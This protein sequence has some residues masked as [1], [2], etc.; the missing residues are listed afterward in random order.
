M[1]S[2]NVNVFDDRGSNSSQSNSR[3]LLSPPQGAN[4]YLLIPTSNYA[5]SSVCSS[6]RHSKTDISGSEVN[7]VTKLKNSTLE[8]VLFIQDNQVKEGIYG[9]VITLLIHLYMFWIGIFLPNLGPEMMYGDWGTWIF[10]VLNYAITLSFERIPYKG[11]IVLAFI[12]VGIVL[13][14]VILLI[15]T[16]F[17]YKTTSQHLKNSRR[18]IAIFSKVFPFIS[19]PLLYLMTFSLDCNYTV[20]SSNLNRFEFYSHEVIQC[21]DTSNIIFVVVMILAILLL[22]ILNVFSM[23]IVPNCHP[24]NIAPFV[25]DNP[26]F[27]SL[28]VAFNLWQLFLHFIIPTQYSFMRAIVHSVG[29]IILII[30]FAKLIPFIRRIENSIVFGCLL[31]RLASS[32]GA[33]VTSIVNNPSLSKILPSVDNTLGVGLAGLTI[34]LIIIGF[35]LGFSLMELY[36]RFIVRSIRNFVLECIQSDNDETNLDSKETEKY[37]EK[38]AQIIYQQLVESRKLRHLRIFF[39]FSMKFK[40][41]Y[42]TEKS[43]TPTQHNLLDIYICIA[44]IKGFSSNN[45]LDNEIILLSSMI[46]ANYLPNEVNSTTFAQGLLKKAFKRRPSTYYNLLISLAQKQVEATVYQ[47]N[48]ESRN[49]VEMAK[50]IGHLE[51]RQD[52]LRALHRAFWKEIMQENINHEKC[53]SIIVRI[54]ILS[55]ECET[56]FK[57][58]MHIYKNDKTVLRCVAKYVESFKFNKEAAQELYSEATT[59]EEEDS[60]RMNASSKRRIKKNQKNRVHPQQISHAFETLSYGD[61]NHHEVESTVVG[62]LNNDFGGVE[63]NPELKKELLF[64][65]ALAISHK[66]HSHLTMFFIFIVLS[67]LIL[68]STLVMSL[69]FSNYVTESVL[70]VDTACTPIASAI[71]IVSGTRSYQS[72]LL[73]YSSNSSAWP[74]LLAEYGYSSLSEFKK[75]HKKELRDNIDYLILLKELAQTA[76]FTT[77]MYSEFHEYYYSFNQPKANTNGLEKIYNSTTAINITIADI[78]NL[79]ITY[80][81]QIYKFEDEDYLHTFSSYPF[82]ILF[83]NR[84]IMTAAYSSFCYKFVEESKSYTKTISNTFIIYYSCSIVVYFTYTAIYLCFARLDLSFLKKLIVL[85]EKNVSKHEA[86]KMYHNLGKLVQDDSSVRPAK[87]SALYPRNVVVGLGIVTAI[88]VALCA[89]LFLAQT[90]SNSQYSFESYVTMRDAFNALENS[91]YIAEAI[92][93]EFINL[94]IADKTFINGLVSSNTERSESIQASIKKLRFYWNMCMYGSN[95]YPDETLV[96]GLFEKTDLMIK[97]EANCTFEKM[98]SHNC[99]IGVDKLITTYTTKA[100]QLTE[101]IDLKSTT[102]ES[103]FDDYLVVSFFSTY[104]SNSLLSFSDV[105]AMAASV[106]S[107]KLVIPFAILGFLT[108]FIFSIGI[109]M[110]MGKYF[111]SVQQLR[112][113]FNYLPLDLMDSNE[114]IKNYIVHHHLPDSFSNIFRRKK[115][116]SSEGDSKVRSILNASVDGAVMCSGEKVDI[117]IFNP[118]AQKIFGYNQTETIGRSLYQ[119]FEK[120][121]QSKIKNLIDEML[122]NAARGD[123]KGDS[124]ELECIRKNQTSFPSRV[125]IFATLHNSQSVVTCFIKD[126]TTEKKHNSL[127]TEE[128]KHSEEL[129]L[130]ILPS[131]VA[132]KLKSGETYI[133]EKFNDVSCFFSDMVGFTK[134]S[135]GI[136]ASELVQMLNE[137]VIGFDDLTDK[138]NLE[139]IKTI[140][141]SYFCV[142]GLHGLNA[143]SDHPERILRFSIDTFDVLQRF[144]SKSG[145]QPSEQINIRVGINTGSVIAGVI[146]RKK[147][148]YVCF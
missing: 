16:I 68:V 148:A 37:I 95:Y 6:D 80:S 144:N 73:L 15:W 106:P 90:L 51:R 115:G 12:G 29:S 48:P 132:S 56:K 97:G 122:V 2:L 81:E 131:A 143:Q 9:Y 10:S 61:A 3:V 96:I 109:Y 34:G 119:L 101:D 104:V 45:Q 25:T 107:D 1:T 108:L 118:A 54:G 123:S 138:Y 38:E 30:I 42:P 39:K 74:S 78:T 87:N 102:F 120:N 128:K 141:D 100:T 22:I 27:M 21:H 83:N 59:I 14:F 135:T 142:G 129:L 113:L 24:Q 4:N 124:I 62:D 147:F 111:N 5:G 89:G 36:T 98:I 127:L 91:Q 41:K 23:L 114:N 35:V 125:N 121:E 47:T 26:V 64:R 13:V 99:S 133:A 57:N 82:M 7:A 140:G 53:E 67:L 112:L 11:G 88:C 33:I 46:I 63:N 44:L 20:S 94:K 116:S 77:D 75:A 86:G 117:E 84:N 55:H 40:E 76:K 52:E 130:N 60:K 79:A 17:A 103:L 65:N 43:E 145:K 71:R 139:K 31:A 126:I 93:E 28:L 72:S 146:G 66:N 110:S 8:F 137:I 92:T 134:L 105:F 69:M 18:A 70:V 50:L 136:Q 32:I 58:L 19:V 49:N 85:L